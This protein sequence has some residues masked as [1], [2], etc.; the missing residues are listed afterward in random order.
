M[1]VIVVGMLLLLINFLIVR[2]FVPRCYCCY[3][4]L[5]LLVCC[6]FIIISILLLL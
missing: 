3:G 2:L 6:S 1:F 4:L 5:V